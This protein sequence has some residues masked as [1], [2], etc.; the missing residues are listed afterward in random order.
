MQPTI[1]SQTD[2]Q[3]RK[4]WTE[5]LGPQPPGRV[6]GGCRG[7]TFRK[8][9]AVVSPCRIALRHTNASRSYLKSGPSAAE[10][11][12]VELIVEKKGV[13]DAEI[14]DALGNS[15]GYEVRR[16]RG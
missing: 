15:D 16:Y 6:C 9:P 13:S 7:G 4:A 11:K 2:F 3:S 14:K 5:G 10:V 12:G 1:A 8:D